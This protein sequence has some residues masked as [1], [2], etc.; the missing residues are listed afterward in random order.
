MTAADNAADL[1]G[2]LM[3][4]DPSL[5]A[6]RVFIS[7]PRGGVT[8][9]WAERIHDEL[10]RR[11]A[12]V[13]RDTHG[14]A[15]GDEWYRRIVDALELADVVVGVFGPDSDDSRWQRREVI[16]A[17]R[18]GLAVVPVA[19]GTHRLPLMAVDRQPIVLRDPGSAAAAYEALARAV[20]EATR[21]DARFR[22]APSVEPP[23]VTPPDEAR[24]REEIAWLNDQIHAA[25]RDRDLQYEPLAGE[26]S[27]ASRGER[28]R[29]QLRFDPQVMLRMFGVGVE[30]VSAAERPV[31][32]DDVLDAY[33]EL[34][35]QRE[36]RLVVLG[37]PGAGKTFSLQRIVLSH[38][39]RALDS[40]TAP[41]PIFVGLG[42]W[43]R[44]D[45]TLLAFIEQQLGPLGRHLETW[46]SERR[47][48]LLLDGLNEIPL[49]QREM[50]ARQIRELADDA[51]WPAVIV[52]CRERDYAADFRLPF[53]QIVLQPLTVLQIHSC[54]RRSLE[55]VHGAGQGAAEAE[56]RFWEIAGGAALREVW[57]VWRAAGASLEL[58]WTADEVPRSDPAVVGKTRGVQDRLWHAA[59][60]DPRSLLR[61]ASN[62]YLL[63]LLIALP[64]MPRNRAQLFDGF[65]GMLHD[66]E[67]QVREERHEAVPERGSWL[68]TLASLAG[69]L[70]RRYGDASSERERDVAATSL[71]RALWPAGVEQVL[72]FSIDASVLQ[73]IG[74]DLRF[75]HQMLQEALAGRALQRML[76]EGTPATGLWP[77]ERW[78]HRNGWEVAAELA[79]ESLA[80]DEPALHRM[81]QW[82]AT[83]N[84]DVACEAWQR[85]G[86]PRLPAL[87]LEAVAA[88]WSESM[89][90]VER[91][92]APPARA[93]IGRL[94]GGLGLDRRIGISVDARGMPVFDWLRIDGTKA[95]TFQH[96]RHAPLPPFEI[97]RYPTT[98]S[99]FQAFIDAGGYEPDSPWWDGLAHRFTAARDPAW[100]EPNAPR[101]RVSW[102]EAVAFCRW[103]SHATG[104]A[105][106]L[107]SEQQWERVAR[108]PDGRLYP[109]GPDYAA[110]RANA[111]ESRRGLA[112]AVSLGRT[113]AV[114]I[115]P[116]GASV[117]GVLDL[118]GNVWE[119]CANEFGNP[120]KLAP[121]GDATRVLRGGSW[122]N[123][124]KNLRTTARD[125]QRPDFRGYQTGFRI[126]RA[127]AA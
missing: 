100:S 2:A 115:Y 64:S 7:Y 94:L 112:G 1:G 70:Q 60:T 105:H 61:L 97:A 19:V 57:D 43:T 12:D 98:H 104:R 68:A 51:R 66:R 124:P 46:R 41:L 77:A 127:C 4:D 10:S 45:L 42:L 99:Q 106:A 122:V 25:L 120:R 52:S 39:R 80:F 38:A 79:C 96:G 90:S 5:H 33:R 110:G 78:W 118:A 11:G 87:L 117:D 36:P 37:E 30:G 88:R 13:W 18:M 107:P 6:L 84:P 62:P 95:F 32:Y 71:P 44:A 63:S 35:S 21:R 85:A 23:T 83:A 20:L 126:C 113:S 55:L 69:A 28:L 76:A 82:L 3:S 15:D 9:T 111:N 34:P 8:H 89:T 73:L 119:W 114:G 31:H 27:P 16:Y 121:T 56:Q 81:L 75:T 40:A 54:L 48:L 26:R 103:L 72:A 101:D 50:K 74:D 14:I 65:F 102:Y 67:R 58:F 49:P 93:A 91:E 125:E 17:D 116:G 123:G 86:A 108:D 92:P 109:W 24:R 59:R 29:H 47:A 22:Q 53:D